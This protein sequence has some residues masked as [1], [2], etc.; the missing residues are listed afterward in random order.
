MTQSFD[1]R[2]DTHQRACRCRSPI[3]TTAQPT[4]DRPALAVS[5]GTTYIFQV[6]VDDGEFTDSD[7]VTI[8][9][10]PVHHCTNSDP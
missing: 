7:T 1:L 10:R 6:I 2:L 3:R 4:F 9:V 5:V 8:T